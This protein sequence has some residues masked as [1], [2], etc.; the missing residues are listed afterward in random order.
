MDT[1]H[2]AESQ[3][4]QTSPTGPFRQLL[5]DALRY[6]EPR[7]LT[8]NLVLFA[9]ALFWLVKTW[10]HFRPALALSPLLRLSV[11][12]L[13]A[14]VCYSVAYLVD[15]PFQC[16]AA[17]TVWKNRRWGLWLAGTL[18]AILLESYWILD[19]IYPDFN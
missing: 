3:G 1:A 13:L 7:R 5:A 14:N 12:A 8:Y 11:L 16:S 2:P 17:S 4:F 10:P 19:E 18:F 15:I 9:V 6:W